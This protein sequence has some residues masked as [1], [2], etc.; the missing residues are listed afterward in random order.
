M[1]EL[2]THML[3]LYVLLIAQTRT[4]DMKEVLSFELGPILWSV[5]SIDGSPNKTTKSVL[6]SQLEKDI[7]LV[8][9]IP[10]EAVYM[11]F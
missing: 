5:A 10:H 11:D 2:R 6:T 9:P 4:M 7:E 8:T 1:H 3:M